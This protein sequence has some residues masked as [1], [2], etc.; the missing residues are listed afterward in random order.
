MTAPFDASC[1]TADGGLNGVGGFY[2]VED[3]VAGRSPI[4]GT[5]IADTFLSSFCLIDR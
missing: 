5:A 4:L 1:S 2:G 3:V